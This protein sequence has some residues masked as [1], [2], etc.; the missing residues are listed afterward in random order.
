MWETIFYIIFGYL[1][2]SVLY[3]RVF[4]KLFQREG[5]LER[6]RDGNPGTANAFLYGGFGC[7]LLTL[8]GDLAKGFLPVY[9]FTHYGAVEYGT[10]RQV[11]MSALVLAAPVAGHAFPLFYGFRGGKGIAATFGSLL[12][13]LPMWQPV[14]ALAVFFL[15]FSIVLRVTPHYHR[16]LIAYLC[17]LVSILCLVEG[18][19]IRTG[20]LLIT[21]TVCGRMLASK[22]E[23]EKV[24]VKLLWMH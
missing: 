2:G 10:F 16:T 1:S 18:T 12:G 20:F 23:R 9:L 6:S 21:L 11:F 19:V 17:S 3:A 8:A 13:L 4:T 15:F 5:V 7:G 22:E 14:A 24:G